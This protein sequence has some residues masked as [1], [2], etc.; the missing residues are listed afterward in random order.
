MLTLLSLSVKMAVS[1]RATPDTQSLIQRT[2]LIKR[3]SSLLQSVIYKL[4]I[5]SSIVKRE[6]VDEYRPITQAMESAHRKSIL[7][8]SDG[9][10]IVLPTLSHGR[11][12]HHRIAP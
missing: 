6:G 5:E 7:N 9:L 2:T 8:G 10:T 11:T 3:L 1:P 12:D 4:W